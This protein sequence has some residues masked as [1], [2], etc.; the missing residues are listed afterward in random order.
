L[1]GHFKQISVYDRKKTAIA[2]TILNIV[3]VMYT[4]CLN[5]CWWCNHC[6][7]KFTS[8]LSRLH[9]STLN[10]ISYSII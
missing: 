6:N 10:C 8:H 9:N 7:A 2:T 3:K 1:F 5:S 4:I